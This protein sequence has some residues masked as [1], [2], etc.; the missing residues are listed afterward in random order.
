MASTEPQNAGSPPRSYGLHFT[1]ER[2]TVSRV[3]Q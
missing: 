2:G 1:F 3:R